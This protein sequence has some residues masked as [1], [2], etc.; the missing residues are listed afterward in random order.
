MTKTTCHGSVESVSVSVWSIEL[1][2]MEGSNADH[3]DWHFMDCTLMTILLE[4]FTGNMACLQISICVCSI[5]VFYKFHGIVTFLF[6]N[7][8]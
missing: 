2:L 6:P 7:T 4:Y 3:Y 8:G 5:R 1:T